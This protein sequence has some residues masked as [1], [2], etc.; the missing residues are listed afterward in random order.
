MNTDIYTPNRIDSIVAQVAQSFST[1][2]GGKESTWGNPLSAILKD[3][4]AQFAAGV[5]VKE[6]VTMVLRLAAQP[7]N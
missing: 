6:V 1:F 3:K 2:G 5:D 7:N 4:P